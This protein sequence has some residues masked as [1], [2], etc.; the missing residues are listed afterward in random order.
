M[1]TALQGVVPGNRVD[2]QLIALE[3]ARV[4]APTTFLYFAWVTG[5]WPIQKPVVM[6]TEC[7]GFSSPLHWESCGEQSMWNLPAGIET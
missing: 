2:R 1:P 3:C 6:V 5:V 4:G 7:A